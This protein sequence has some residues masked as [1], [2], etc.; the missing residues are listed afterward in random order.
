M[1]RRLRN[2]MA[3]TATD[4]KRLRQIVRII[5][6]AMG[7]KVYSIY[8]RSADNVLELCATEGLNPEAVH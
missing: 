3:Q 6:A 8:V 7:A 1:L 5:A 2:V 4:Q